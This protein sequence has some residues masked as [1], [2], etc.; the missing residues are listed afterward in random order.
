MTRPG[1]T[2][3]SVGMRTEMRINVA[4]DANAAEA[5]TDDVDDDNAVDNHA[6]IDRY[7]D[8]TDD[9]HMDPAHAFRRAAIDPRLQ[10]IRRL[11]CK[12]AVTIIVYDVATNIP[13]C[14]LAEMSHTVIRT[15]AEKMRNRGP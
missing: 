12:A 4:D 14:L 15:A 13:I 2:Y 5:D 1:A 9:Q 3:T 8:Y 6:Y 11:I 10:A 7:L